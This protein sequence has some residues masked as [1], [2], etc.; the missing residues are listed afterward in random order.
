MD[1]SMQMVGIASFLDHAD[2]KMLYRYTFIFKYKRGVFNH[3]G[4]IRIYQEITD[5]RVLRIGL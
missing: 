3:Q 1:H 4:Y 5:S 2:E